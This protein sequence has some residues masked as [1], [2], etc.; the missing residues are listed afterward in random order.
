MPNAIELVGEY[1][2]KQAL[3]PIIGRTKRKAI[4]VAVTQAVTT[5]PILRNTQASTAAASASKAL[6][7]QASTAIPAITATT[8]QVPKRGRE[9]P[10][11]AK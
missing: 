11:K 9:R 2:V 6:A 5:I 10:P 1:E 3:I 4:K 8:T 7:T